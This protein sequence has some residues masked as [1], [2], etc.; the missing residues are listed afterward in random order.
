MI[1]MGMFR[2]GMFGLDD[3]LPC[4]G[5][6]LFQLRKACSTSTC[7]ALKQNEPRLLWFCVRRSDPEL[8]FVI[9]GPFPKV[10]KQNG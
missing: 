6:E 1:L 10:A 9:K 8:N 5:F 2:F 4:L 7:S 3:F